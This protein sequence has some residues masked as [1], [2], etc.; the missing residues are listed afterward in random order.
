MIWLPVILHQMLIERQFSTVQQIESVD[1]RQL[2]QQPYNV[3]I[4]VMIVFWTCLLV[5]FYSN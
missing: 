1:S 5:L 2:K 3:H 4:F